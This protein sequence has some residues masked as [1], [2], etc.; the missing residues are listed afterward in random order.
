[1]PN[2][3]F[4]QLGP[5]FSA[6]ALVTSPK[7]YHYAAGTVTLKNIWSDRGETT[8]LAQPFVG[9][10]NGVFNFF[11]DGLYKLVV[12]DSAD[13]TLYTLDNFLIQDFLTPTFAEGS[14]ISSASTV[15]VGPEI[16]AH[17]TGTTT[18]DALSGTIPF[19]WAVFDG[20][21]TLTHSSSLLCPGSTNLLVEPG[22]VVLFL[23]ENGS[24]IF[25]VAGHLGQSLLTGPNDVEVSVEDARTTSV[26]APFTVT[27][28]TTNTPAA[29]IGTGILFKAESA[30]ENPSNFGQI[31]AVASDVGAGSEDTYF[32]MLLRVA[33]A[34]LAAAYRWAATTAYNAIFTHANTANRTYTLANRSCTLGHRY[35]TP[36]STGSGST[37]AHEGS[38]TISGNQALNG[39]HFYTDF[40]LNSGVTITPANDSRFLAIYATGTITINGTIAANGAGATGAPTTS[41][42]TAGS[43][44]D[45]GTDQPAGN[46]G[47]GNVGTYLGGVGGDA[48]IHG[49][50]ISSGSTQIS[51]GAIP[52]LPFPICA[53]GGAGG[54]SGGGGNTGN[55]GAGGDGG[56]SII[57]VAPTVVLAATATLNTSGANGSAGTSANGGGGGG[58]GAGNIYILCH[59]FT[60]SGAT[61]TQDGGSA[62]SGS[63][64][65]NDGSAGADGVKQINI[66]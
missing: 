33:G 30:D 17:I 24:S 64:L 19:F 36:T 51:G 5:F 21:L 60:D 35:D 28:T 26:D 27:S 62:G 44:G 47:S 29:G 46:G 22:D 31:E 14:P 13:N 58:G 37:L 53:L 48:Y 11:A 15:A 10:A 23:N 25:R 43:D 9:D 42:S 20:S 18:I 40:T 34:P 38:V 32:Q 12:K 63:G 54:G 6:G 8:T 2:A 41:V 59:S 49:I 57:L 16:W 52:L 39:V 65:G 4:L 50:Q 7:L 56:A 55:G 45:N 3:Q 1:M 66:Y 61:I